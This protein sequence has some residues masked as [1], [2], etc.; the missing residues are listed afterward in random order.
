MAEMRIVV[1]D[2][3]GTMDRHTTRYQIAHGKDSTH[4]DL[5]TEHARPVEEIRSTKGAVPNPNPATVHLAPVADLEE[6]T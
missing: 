1:C 2:V 6:R 4:Y 3:C 5:C